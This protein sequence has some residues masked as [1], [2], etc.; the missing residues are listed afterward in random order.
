MQAR[1]VACLGVRDRSWRRTTRAGCF[2]RPGRCSDASTGPT[3]PRR[4]RAAGPRTLSRSPLSRPPTLGGSA[5][6]HAKPGEYQPP[7]CW[8]ETEADSGVVWR[9]WASNSCTSR[10]RIHRF[11]PQTGPTSRLPLRG[12][13]FAR[14]GGRPRDIGADSDPG[15]RAHLHHASDGVASGRTTPGTREAYIPADHPQERSRRASQLCGASGTEAG[16]RSRDAPP[17]SRR[18]RRGLPGRRIDR[19]RRPVRRRQHPGEVAGGAPNRLGSGRE[20]GEARSV[21]EAL[22]VP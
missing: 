20:L 19:P 11:R 5:W 4:Q 22:E 16:Y 14:N 7:Y 3:R 9:P 15:C 17:S 12:L 1:R 8:A 10:G 13:I 21:V 18:G 6:T 2:R